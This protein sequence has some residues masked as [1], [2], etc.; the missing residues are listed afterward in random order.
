MEMKEAG[1]CPMMDMTS[2]KDATVVTENL[3]DGVVM[4]ITAK[5]PAT[6]KKIQDMGA[7]I[8]AMHEHK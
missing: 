8:S 4:K 1:A 2:L 7:K 5:D 3:K 6:V